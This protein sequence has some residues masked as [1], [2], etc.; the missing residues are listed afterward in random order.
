MQLTGKIGETI[1]ISGSNF[2]R[3]SRVLFS[4][5]KSEF[6]I[7]SENLIKARVPEGA[8]WDYI[9]IISDERNATGI[10]SEKF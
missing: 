8:A 3:I 2:S 10:S 1:D 7:V 9:K 5:V 4:D 6:Q